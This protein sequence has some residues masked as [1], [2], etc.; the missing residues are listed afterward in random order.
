[1]ARQYKGDEKLFGNDSYKRTSRDVVE[2]RNGGYG[3]LHD[4]NHHRKVQ[5]RWRNDWDGPF[6]DD[7]IFLLEIGGRKVDVAGEKITIA[8]SKEELLRWLRYI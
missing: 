7:M 8:L 3:D 5:I 2:E 4:F 1:M 6:E